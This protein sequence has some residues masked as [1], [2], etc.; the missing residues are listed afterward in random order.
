MVELTEK[1][2]GY[3]SIF[4]SVAG[5]MPLDYIESENFIIFII[6]QL[7]IGK[8]IGKGGINIEK[9]SRIFKKKVVAV[10]DSSDPEIFI[11]NFLKNTNILS[12][13]SRDVMGEHE[14]IITVDERDRG[15]A[16]GRGGERIKALKELMK[17]KFKS[18]IHL[19]TRRILE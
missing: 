16:I 3:F 11:R 10:A 9:L 13:E 2:L 18:N 17:R 4:E 7:Q 14:F 1:G 8:A 19:R 5:V 12:I 6:N 15:T